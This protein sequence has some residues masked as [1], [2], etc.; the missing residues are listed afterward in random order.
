MAEVNT[1]VIPSVP[2]SFRV[3]KTVPVLH[4]TSEEGCVSWISLGSTCRRTLQSYSRQ[5]LTMLSRFACNS[6][7]FCVSLLTVWTH[8][9]T[10]ERVT[11][12]KTLDTKTLALG[13]TLSTDLATSGKAC[14]PPSTPTPQD[15]LQRPRNQ[16]QQ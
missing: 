2:C 5:N 9:A 16:K 3:R 4:H 13:C 11:T 1:M 14:P 8:L 6:G 10:F 15:V 7:C 12:R